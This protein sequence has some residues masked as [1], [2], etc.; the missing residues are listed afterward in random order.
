MGMTGI[1]RSIKRAMLHVRLGLQH[2]FFPSAAVII[3]YYDAEMTKMRRQLLESV[4]VS[5]DAADNM[6][7]LYRQGMMY[8]QTPDFKQYEADQV[9]TTSEKP[10]EMFNSRRPGFY[11][12]WMSYD[13]LTKD[14]K[15]EVSVYTYDDKNVARRHTVWT[16]ELVDVTE[17]MIG[18]LPEIWAPYGYRI[19]LRQ[20]FG[21][22]CTI[23]YAVYCR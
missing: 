9:R 20:V 18:T 19:M 12:L 21:R 4:K 8:Q 5:L 10:L 6:V 22:S 11:G 1:W 3:D 2:F 7:M 14:D 17:S 15:I 16:V 13:G 23:P